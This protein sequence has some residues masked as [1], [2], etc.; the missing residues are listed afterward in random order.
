MHGNISLVD[1]I[2]CVEV[3]RLG[4]NDVLVCLSLLRVLGWAC[5][6]NDIDDIHDFFAMQHYMF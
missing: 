2:A 4:Q 1:T 3:W 5:R 6:I